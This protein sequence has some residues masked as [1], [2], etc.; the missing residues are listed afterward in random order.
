M[1]YDQDLNVANLLSDG[2][3]RINI[4]VLRSF[5]NHPVNVLFRYEDF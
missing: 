2:V 1:D 3:D 5:Q 4:Q